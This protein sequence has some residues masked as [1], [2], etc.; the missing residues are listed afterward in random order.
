MQW[1]LAADSKLENKIKTHKTG[2]KNKT[3][4]LPIYL[5]LTQALLLVI[6]PG[7][8]FFWRRQFIPGHQIFSQSVLYI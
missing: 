3:F 7:H 4:L 6:S 2:M 5:T 1:E 8:A